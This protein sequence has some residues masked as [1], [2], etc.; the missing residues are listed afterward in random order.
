MMFRETDTL[1]KNSRDLSTMLSSY[2]LLKRQVYLGD[3][4]GNILEKT[5][6]YMVAI[7][8]HTKSSIKTKL[9]PL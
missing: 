6:S 8:L 1:C 2:Y 4:I 7:N 9:S 3:F 5:E